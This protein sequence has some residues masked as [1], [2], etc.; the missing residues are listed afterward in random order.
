MSVSELKQLLIHRIN[1]ID[2]ESYLN[3]IKIL[4]DPGH[5]EDRTACRG[6]RY[7][8]NE[9]EKQKIA[10]AKQQIKEGKVMSHEKVVGNLQ[11]WL[12]E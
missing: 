3:A 12:E 7:E 5:D 2:D 11:K 8:L 6:T 4:T 10:N 1:S 9:F